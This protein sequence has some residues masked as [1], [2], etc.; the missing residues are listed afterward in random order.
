MFSDK[1]TDKLEQ[2][3]QDVACNQDIL[4]LMTD[5]F[6]GVALRYSPLK[7]FVQFQINEC[8]NNG[9]TLTQEGFQIGEPWNGDIL[10]APIL[11]LSSNPA[12]N[13]FEAS[14]RL[15]K[16][17]SITIP[18]HG[19]NPEEYMKLESIQNFLRC[20]IQ[21][22]PEN[23]NSP[24]VL[25]I[26]LI[27]GNPLG[28]NIDSVSYWGNVRNR[29]E[30]LLPANLTAGWKA[31]PELSQKDYARKIMKYAV[32]TEIVPFRSSAQNGVN[33]NSLSFCWDNFAQRILSIAGAS[34]FILVGQSALN[35][36]VDK[37]GD[38][39]ALA[40]LNSGNIY[41]RKIG[42]RDR[43][44]IRLGFNC[45]N[46]YKLDG[47]PNNGSINPATLTELKSAVAKAI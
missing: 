23:Q 35:T 4:N 39:Q 43:L 42:G 11:F 32:C 20:R 15:H 30:G 46:I 12:F 27:N 16:D 41:Q 34:V 44:I 31:N 2:I 45:G 9:T 47:N 19:N 18:A 21:D 36:F 24:Q 6:R 25:N 10:N 3:I 5:C 13:F 8:Q 33:N 37:V 29:T 38:A 28:Q 1:V 7:D 17:G 14:P 40:T 26:P 22:S